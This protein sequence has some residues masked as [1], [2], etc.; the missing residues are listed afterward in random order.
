MVDLSAILIPNKDEMR[1]TTLYLACT[2]VSGTGAWFVFR[3]ANQLGLLDVPNERSSHEIAAPIPKGA[4]VGIL[5]AFVLASLQ[6]G[7]PINF[8][9]SATILA[10]LSLMGD[11]VD[12]APKFRLVLQF[13]AAFVL[14]FPVQATGPTYL[15]ICFLLSVFIVGTANFYNFMDGINGICG[16]AGAVGFGFLSV[17]AFLS[18]GYSAFVVLGICMSFACLGFLPFNF[19]KARVFMG[20]VGSILLG[21]VFASM[22]VVLARNLR[23]LVCMAAFLFPFYAD[24]LGTMAVRLRDDS[25]RERASSSGTS[26]FGRWRIEMFLGRLRRLAKPHRRHVYQLLVNEIGLAHWKVSVGYG[27]L[28]VV[29]GIGALVVQGIG[30]AWLLSYLGIC[31]VGFWV[32]GAWTRLRA[33]EMAARELCVP[34]RLGG[35]A[36]FTDSPQP[37]DAEEAI[38]A[39]TSG[40]KKR[41]DEVHKNVGLMN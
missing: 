35:V 32:F 5:A 4:G 20:D 8:W 18:Q 26:Y 24:E 29:V 12:I 3:F 37:A 30:M 10:L 36:P 13:I 34:E 41:R 15:L 6:L 14:L 21:F 39:A 31:S 19:P 2:V 28:Q 23:D 40:H 33:D 7:I 27:V 22:A 16:I 25:Q 9:L 11:R 38:K 17:F 1:T